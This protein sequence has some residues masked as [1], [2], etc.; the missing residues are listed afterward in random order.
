MRRVAGAIRLLVVVASLTAVI[1]CGSSPTPPIAPQP[2]QTS[3]TITGNLSYTGVAQQGQLTATAGYADG[4]TRDIT[5]SVTWTPQITTVATISPTGVLTTTGL[6]GTYIGAQNNAVGASSR[7]YFQTVLVKVT[8]PGTLALFGW[9]REPG[10]GPLAGVSVR[11]AQSGQSTMSNT[12]GDYALGGL[13]SGVLT[14]TK[15]GYEDVQF[16][17]GDTYDGWPL[18]QVVRV[19]AGASVSQRLAPHDVDYVVTGSTHCQPCRL[20]RVTNTTAGTLHVRVTWT[21]PA[22]TLNLWVNGQVFPG[23]SATPEITAEVTAGV[24]ELLMY[25]GKLQSGTVGNYVPFTFSTSR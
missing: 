21:E 20:I 12:N 19:E 8:P 18:Q 3:F 17:T 25:V 2:V 23:S 10:S 24:G 9:T 13:T 14:F 7:Y 4:T 15:S 1:R 6:G 11:E 5:T 22:S 16:D